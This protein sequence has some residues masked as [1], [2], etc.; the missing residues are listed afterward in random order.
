MSPQPT[1]SSW[2]G[3]PYTRLKLSSSR[4]CCSSNMKG[5]MTVLEN[6]KEISGR[7]EGATW[8]GI[9]SLTQ[10][11][12]LGGHQLELNLVGVLA[13]LLS[14]T[15]VLDVLN[16][17]L[18]VCFLF[19]IVKGQRLQEFPEEL[20]AFFLAMLI[21][22]VLSLRGTFLACDLLG[23]HFYVSVFQLTVQLPL[24]SLSS[25]LFFLQ[26]FPTMLILGH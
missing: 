26:F 11:F 3:R 7:T 20:R 22:Q 23:L 1:T 13:S 24:L 21:P 15:T 8:G 14:M 9:F 6:S 12:I 2:G 19:E 25:I 4:I 16:V 5:M 18:K 17:C 10:T